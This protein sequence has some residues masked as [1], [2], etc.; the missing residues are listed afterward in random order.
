MSRFPIVAL[1]EH[2]ERCT[3]EVTETSCPLCNQICPLNEMDAHVKSCTGEEVKS[4]TGEEVHTSSPRVTVTP[5]PYTTVDMACPYCYGGPFSFAGLQSHVETCSH[6]PPAS[7][8]TVTDNGEEA[9]VEA[10]GEGQ[11]AMTPEQAQEATEVDLSL[12][13]DEALEVNPPVQSSGEEGGGGTEVEDGGESCVEMEVKG[14][15][16]AEDEE[17]D[18]DSD[19]VEV[20]KSRGGE[21]MVCLRMYDGCGSAF[22]GAT[23]PTCNK[24][25]RGMWSRVSETGMEQAMVKMGDKVTYY[26]ESCK[27]KMPWTGNIVELLPNKKDP[28][29]GKLRIR[30]G[31]EG[32]VYR[33]GKYDEIHAMSKV[34]VQGF[35]VPPIAKRQRKPPQRLSESK[36]TPDGS[37]GHSRKRQR[38]QSD[39]QS[40]SKHSGHASKGS[41]RAKARK[42]KHSV[43]ARKKARAS[44]PAAAAVPSVAC[45]PV[46]IAL[47]Y[48]KKA[49]THQEGKANGCSPKKRPAPQAS[50]RGICMLCKANNGVRRLAGPTCA[51]CSNFCHLDCWTK[52]TREPSSPHY[53]QGE[54]WCSDCMT[55]DNT[56]SSGE[57]DGVAGILSDGEESC[58]SWPSASV[59]EARQ[60]EPAFVCSDVLE[61]QGGGGGRC[62]GGGEDDEGEEG[63]DSQAGQ[64]PPEREREPEPVPVPVPVVPVPVPLPTAIEKVLPGGFMTHSQWKK[65]LKTAFEEL[66]EGGRDD[67]EARKG[68]TG[69]IEVD[70]RRTMYGS[71]YEGGVSQLIEM[72]RINQATNF[73]D[74]GSGIGQVVM[75][76]AALTGAKCTG[77]EVAP[78]R[79]DA[80]CELLDQVIATA[81][82]QTDMRVAELSKL[83]DRV[84]LIKADFT[85][86]ED[87]IKSADVIFFNNFAGWFSQKENDRTKPGTS[88]GE[89]KL[90]RMLANR[91]GFHLITLEEL[92]TPPKAWVVQMSKEEMQPGQVSWGASEENQ[93]TRRLP[94][95]HYQIWWQEWQCHHCEHMNEPL[96]D[97]CFICHNKSRLQHQKRSGRQYPISYAEVGDSHTNYTKQMCNV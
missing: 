51:R 70:G 47:T 27:Q 63:D 38:K 57:G 56:S 3:G 89:D 60:V 79:H 22:K 75:Q 24:V 72:A 64:V 67:F 91:R 77:I 82:Q 15:A 11:G 32:Y 48:R 50:T 90:V 4:C 23:C 43:V 31:N 52:A 94:F 17:E 74:I 73:L 85:K 19:V 58:R 59:G 71:L 36:S 29:S 80:A 55:K 93:H 45:P 6:R 97:S 54:Y 5:S 96:A 18:A 8:G 53:M 62:V 68:I 21:E 76:V 66:A 2:A 40:D 41:S 39:N 9:D 88:C 81:E 28:T 78:K 92:L 16:V 33:D 44:A 37:K 49:L 46:A 1:F 65:V 30:Y 34:T 86:Q 13:S 10:E 84:D 25:R 83:R 7:D 42:G 87:V 20:V 35:V 14:E 69:C 12:P 26:P 95:Y 61:P